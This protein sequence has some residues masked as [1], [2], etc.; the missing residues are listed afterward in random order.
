MARMTIDSLEAKIKKLKKVLSEQ[1]RSIIRR[2]R[3][4]RS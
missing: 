4:C 1:V 3:T 2:V